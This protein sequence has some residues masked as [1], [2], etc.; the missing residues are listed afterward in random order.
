MSID[1][2]VLVGGG[3]SN[4]L[5]LKK[6]LMKPSLM[7]NLPISIISRDSY[8]VYSS[9]YSS[10]ISKSIP[11]SK[12][13]IDISALA[14]SSKVSF[15]KDEVCGINFDENKVFIENRPYIYYSKLVLNMGMNTLISDE[16]KDLVDRKIAFTI[17][18]FFASY[19]FIE[20]EDLHNTEKELPFVIVGSGLAA[21]EIAFALRKRWLK[22]S[23]V[24]VCNFKKLNKKFI[25]SLKR[26]Q[27]SLSATLDFNY[28]RILLCTGN[29]PHSWIK[30]NNLDLDCK[31]R[32]IT[33]SELRV[34]DYKNIFAVGDCACIGLNNNSSSGILAVKS[35]STLSKNLFNDFNGRRLNKWRP[36]KVGLQ[37]VNLFN[38]NSKGKAFA[39]YGK[40]GL[41]PYHLFWLLKNKID[42]SFIMQFKLPPISSD[43]DKLMNNSLDCRGCAAKIPQNILNQSLRKAQLKDFADFPEDASIIYENNQ[44]ILLGSVDGFPALISDPFLN[45][46]ITTLHACSDLWACGAKVSSAQVLISIPKVADDYQQY[47][48]SQSLGGIKSIMDNLN[49][50]II[51]GHSY[52]SRN[53]TEKPYT[54]SIDISLT[55]QGILKTGRNSW[56]KYGMQPGDVLLMS[57]PL[58]AGI[59]FAAQMRNLQV[60][61]SYESV[62]NKLI[63][64]QQ[65][66]I[67]QIN[68]LQDMVGE[69][70]VHAATDI[71]GYG[72]LGHLKEMIDASNS[73]RIKNNFSKIKVLLDLPSF[74]AYPGVF[75]LIRKG[76]RSS[77][78]LE[79]KKIFDQVFSQK[80]GEET[81]IFSKEKYS[82][83]NE[84]FE[85]VEL[86]IDPQTC[87]PLLISCESKYY[88]YLNSNWYKVGEVVEK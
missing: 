63:S 77:L 32:I 27:I 50:K 70:I 36:K 8:L 20:S 81:I 34:N 59:F 66:L 12:S 58:G 43:K 76:I 87:G 33:N 73:K 64:S 65:F 22:R 67:D 37:L 6:W 19:K 18:P 45:A 56:K 62:F 57:R 30:R 24:L 61:E 2:L 52:E 51:G 60:F 72:F 78:F 4:V 49:A 46:K 42:S 29:E 26:S 44:E 82:F 74:K 23:I 9:M 16:F 10:V 1:H 85:K 14:K 39:I 40:I 11:L 86:L 83:D 7:P 17:K 3:H 69:K 71:T 84:F 75:D 21:V 79:N 54:L 13:L 47:L 25:K 31:G 28:K 41:G 48:L 55:V 53:Y 5:L 88:E 68:S 38:A 15:I 80:Y 35:S